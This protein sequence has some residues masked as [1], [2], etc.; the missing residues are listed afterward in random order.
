MQLPGTRSKLLTLF[1]SYFDFIYRM[2][3]KVLP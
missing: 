2:D 1:I 3:L